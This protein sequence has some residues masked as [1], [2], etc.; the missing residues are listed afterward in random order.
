[1][2]HLSTTFVVDP[3]DKFVGPWG[4]TIADRTVG[5]A[6]VPAFTLL[7][8]LVPFEFTEQGQRLTWYACPRSDGYWGDYFGVTQL[9]NPFVVNPLNP[10]AIGGW[11]NV[12]GF[13]DSRPATGPAGG[14][15]PCYWETDALGTPQ[16]ISSSTWLSADL[17]Q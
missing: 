9:W 16:H 1:M 17:V 2:G 4:V 3:D 14:G 10:F 11:E 15:V 6:Q 8:P 5:T 13:T 7:W 12:A